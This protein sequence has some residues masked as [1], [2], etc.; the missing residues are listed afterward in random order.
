MPSTISFLSD[1]KYGKSVVLF[2]LS[3]AG[4]LVDTSV[5]GKNLYGRLSFEAEP[6]TIPGLAP[7]N[8]FRFSEIAVHWA[9][10]LEFSFSHAD[11]VLIFVPGKQKYLEITKERLLEQNPDLY[12]FWFYR[13]TCEEYVAEE[14]ESAYSLTQASIPESAS[15]PALAPASTSASVPTHDRLQDVQDALSA[16][17]DAGWSYNAIAKASVVNAVT[18]YNI[19]SGKQSTVSDRVYEAIIQLKS[20]FDAGR[21]E[22]PTRKR[23]AASRLT[24]S[25][26]KQRKKTDKPAQKPS[27]PRY[28]AVDAQKLDDLIDLLIHTLQEG[29]DELEKMK[30][31]VV[32]PTPSR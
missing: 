2:M 15:G 19:K 12:S 20:D 25:S 7:R 28:V 11:H 22:K 21:V 9:D 17:N 4:V 32:N 5:I 23:R 6:I 26:T 31:N 16:L 29:V 10:F 14:P 27:E 24:K 8:G 13:I 3:P 18:I 30:N 1:P